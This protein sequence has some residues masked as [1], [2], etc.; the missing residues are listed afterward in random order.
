LSQL[1]PDF[2]L[3]EI[4]SRIEE[5]SPYIIVAMQECER[6]N[7]LLGTIRKSLSDLDQGL[8]GALNMTDAMEAIAAALRI[9]KV[10]A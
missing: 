9:N 2:N 3:L 7:I 1:P 10:P 8:R 6:M 4:Q 5:M